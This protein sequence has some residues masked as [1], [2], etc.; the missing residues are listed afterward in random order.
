M[1]F[2]TFI[3]GFVNAVHEIPF[4][5][6]IIPLDSFEIKSGLNWRQNALVEPSSAGRA[7]RSISSLGKIGN[8]LW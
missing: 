3:H 1:N 5:D 2:K 6:T 4:Y 8:L 7:K